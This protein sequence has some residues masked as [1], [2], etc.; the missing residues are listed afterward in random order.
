MPSSIF[1]GLGPDMARVVGNLRNIMGNAT[2]EVFAEGLMRVNPQFRQFV[3]A[4]RG[5]SLSQTAS[6]YGVDFQELRR[7]L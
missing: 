5:K 1:G 3:E 2:P 7:H 6:T 4:N